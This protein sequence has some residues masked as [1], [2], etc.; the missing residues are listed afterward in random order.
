M[1]PAVGIDAV[2]ER[3]PAA[4]GLN[5]V[6]MTGRRLLVIL[7]TILSAATLPGCWRPLLSSGTTSKSSTAIPRDEQR[8][9][10]SYGPVDA[11]IKQPLSGDSHAST[12]QPATESEPTAPAWPEK[13]KIA[14]QVRQTVYPR[15]E[16]L[17]GT[18][19]PRLGPAV[20]EAPIPPPE[21]KPVQANRVDSTQKEPLLQAL[22]CV[23]KNHPGE[24]LDHLRSYDAPTQDFF[25]RLLPAMARLTQ[26]SLDQMTP[27]EVAVLQD[28]LEGML[29][30]LR[31]RAELII[32]RM[33]FCEW[34]KGYGSYKP[35]PEGHLFHAGTQERP[36]ELVQVYVELRNLTSDRRGAYHETRLSS[37]VEI[38]DPRDP[39]RGVLWRY[40]FEDNK[41]PLQTLARLPDY[42]KKYNF[43][44]PAHIPPGVYTLTIQVQDETRS[45]KPRLARKSLEFRVTSMPLAP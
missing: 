26:K 27:E 7:G 41:Q 17:G 4:K 16:A 39:S 18:R 37:T 5:E 15:P 3:F 30:S 43:Y 13:S 38:S 12:P 10:T 31:P 24:A 34:I 19:P 35:L 29:E 42:F 6:G 20:S 28:Q 36:G 32:N 40:R 33:C 22:L 11:G 44:V 8:K 45:G 23:L 14:E 1:P 25:I 9:G 2:S 21:N